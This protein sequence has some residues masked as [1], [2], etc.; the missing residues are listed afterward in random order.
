[1]PFTPFSCKRLF[2]LWAVLCT[3]YLFI[4]PAYAS[5][6]FVSAYTDETAGITGLNGASAVA[7]SQNGQ[8]VYVTGFTDNSLNVF[9]RAS[10]TGQLTIVQTLTNADVNNTGLS[11]AIDVLVS[12]DDKH[13]Y[14]ASSKDNALAVFTRNTSTGVLTLAEVLQDD[15]NGVDGLA[16]VNALAISSDGTRLYAI[17]SQENAVAVLQRH[18]DTGLL[19]FLRVRKNGVDGVGGIAGATELAISPDN[20]F[21]YVTASNDNAV[22]VFKRLPTEELEIFA[23]YVN[24]INGISGLNG[25]YGI[26][27]SQ[28]GDYLYVAGNTANSIALFQRDVN[29]GTLSYVKTYINNVEG[30]TGLSGVRHLQLSTDQLSLFA[31]GVNENSLTMFKRSASTGELTFDNVVKNNTNNINSLNGIAQLAVSSDGKHVYTAALFSKAVSLFGLQSTELVLTLTANDKAV[32]ASPFSYSLTVQNT[33]TLAA[34]NVTLTTTLPTGASF[35]QASSDTFNCQ[36]QNQTVTCSLAQLNAGAQAIATLTI[37]APSSIGNLALSAEVSA[38]EPETN[39]ANNSASKTITVADI[40]PEANLGVSIASLPTEVNINSPFTYTINVTNAGADTATNAVLTTTF[41]SDA[42]FVSSSR[43]GCT[44]NV[45]T[46]TCPLGNLANGANE[47]IQ[48]TVNTGSQASDTD[49]IFTAQISSDDL[50]TVPANNNASSTTKFKLLQLDLAITDVLATPNSVTVGS[51]IIYRVNVHNKGGTG[52]Q[53]TVLAADIAPQLSYISSSHGC[54]NTAGKLSCVLGT[55]DATAT[56]SSF[57]TITVR[58]VQASNN[59]TSSFTLSANGTETDN[60]DNTQTTAVTVTGQSADFLVTA[61]GSANPVNINTPLTYTVVVTNNGPASSTAQLQLALQGDNI[62]AQVTQGT[63]T[64]MQG[65]SLSCAI[66][67]LASNESETIELTLTPQ[68]KGVVN[69]TADVVASNNLFDPTLPNQVVLTTAVGQAV[70]DIS[71]NLEANLA[72]IK[73]GE[74]LSLSSKVNN[75]S[76]VDAD[77]VSYSLTLP[78]DVAIQSSES[79]Q[80]QACTVDTGV[81]TCPLGPLTSGAEA[82]VLVKLQAATAGEL[83]AKAEVSTT[84]FDSQQSNNSASQTVAVTQTTA[85]LSVAMTADQSSVFIQTPV[86]YTITVGNAGADPAT[87]VTINTELTGNAQVTQATL[88]PEGSGTCTITEAQVTCTANVLAKD[89]QLTAQLQL[90]PLAVGEL[91]HRVAV[92][93]VQTDAVSANNTAQV[94]ITVKELPPVFFVEAYEDGQTGITGLDRVIALSGSADGKHVY[95][96]GFG[97]QSLVSF[98]RNSNDGRLTFNSAVSQQQIATLTTPTA[99]TLSPDGAYIYVS[100]FSSA[101]INIF[102]RDTETGAASFVASVTNGDNGVSGLSGAVAL[103]ATTQALYVASAGDN[104]LVRFTRNADGTLTFAEK[105]DNLLGI[106]QLAVSPNGLWL[107][108]ANSNAD[109]VSL[110][111]KDNSTGALTLKQTLQDNP[112]ENIYLDAVS[113]LR[114]SPDS[115][116]LY[117]GA[118]GTANKLSAWGLNANNAQLSLI[119]SYDNAGL[120]GIADIAIDKNGQSV[121]AVG[122]NESSL[123]V[124]RRS[125]SQGSLEYIGRLQDNTDDINGLGSARAVFVPETGGHIYVAGFADNAISLFRSA[126]ADI[127]LTATADKATATINDDIS[128]TLTVTHNGGDQASNINLNATLSP[129]LTLTAA[130]ASQ[131]SCQ[132]QQQQVVC[133]VGNLNPQQNLTVTVHTR[134][135][136]LSELKLSATA[137]ADQFDPTAPNSAELSTAIISNAELSSQLDVTP[138][139]VRVGDSVQYSMQLQNIGTDPALNVQLQAQLPETATFESAQIGTDTSL[140]Q[141]NALTVTCTIPRLDVN[142]SAQWLLRI[143][144][145]EIG[146]FTTQFTVQQAQ[147]TLQQPHSLEVGLNI[148][149]ETINN[150]NQT[151]NDYTITAIGAVEGGIL[152]G[153]ITNNGVAI[154]VEVAENAVINGG[155]LSGTITNAGTLHNVQLLSNTHINGGKLSGTITGYPTAPALISAEILAGST[156]RYVTVGTGSKLADDVIIGKGVRFS[157]AQLLPINTPLNSAFTKTTGKGIQGIDLRYD[158]VTSQTGSLLDAINAIPALKDNNISYQQNTDTGVLS[159]LKSKQLELLLPWEIYQADTDSAMGITRFDDGRVQFITADKR[160]IT[161]YPMINAEAALNAEL[162]KLSLPALGL[163]NEA[164]LNIQLPDNILYLLRPA[165]PAEQVSSSTSLGISSTPHSAL[166]NIITWQLVF[167]HQGQR[168]RQHLYPVA[169]Q[170]QE[171]QQVLSAMPAAGNVKILSTGQVDIQL[172]NQVSQVV[173]DY[174]VTQGEASNVTQLLEIPDRNADG[175][176]DTQITYRNGMQQVLFNIPAP[177]WIDEIQGITAIQDAGYVISQTNNNYL[178]LTNSSTRMELEA[179]D[180]STSTDAATMQILDSGEVIFITPAGRKITTVPRLQAPDT[181]ATGALDRNLGALNTDNLTRLILEQSAQQQHLS[182]PALRA[183]PSNRTTGVY[184]L[185]S[186]VANND[187]L[188]VVF[189]D[190]DKK[191]WQQIVYPTAFDEAAVLAFFKLLPDVTEVTLNENG[192]IA[193]IGGQQGFT[194][195]FAYGLTLTPNSSGGIQFVLSDDFNN[196][197]VR[198]FLITFAQ[199]EQQI[200]YQNL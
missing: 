115:K 64:P 34:S 178:V 3:L 68:V 152:A 70:T 46:M 2:L 71:T 186:Q 1:M 156:L 168:Y 102:K 38:V 107:A 138:Q 92:A 60:S 85:D 126:L 49:R 155:K 147:Q 32:K 82:S 30:V 113:T 153:T 81:V 163:T 100:S 5:L 74:V 65:V 198:D 181:F 166:Q 157:S 188:L 25:A 200:I 86:T 58:G 133:S 79:T 47:A 96:V 41:P 182:R 148:I 8:H 59:I 139:R 106:N 118:A 63:C 18:T 11:G 179:V 117:I 43:T 129:A 51:E 192:N 99:V 84:T 61:T 52:A 21:I 119:A 35:S 66:P 87:Q 108:T 19:T 53:E 125:I 122:T 89:A 104:A 37:Q 12:P 149:E 29:T 170:Q 14:V 54:Q 78:A 27:L 167:E 36:T 24:G 146:V 137:F 76:G 197:G 6:T 105:Y 172:V 141:H 101:S 55:L 196:D 48:I 95:A 187:M 80:G 83:T 161:A 91:I 142:G 193:V 184:T 112:S 134:V 42:S 143:K 191:R 151:L 169:A 124:Y 33:S 16:G 69:L 116:H 56:P 110:F 164:A 158:I 88:S 189:E 4:S 26:T 72:D 128:Y 90:T 199:G 177:S 175:E 103:Q 130:V 39:T 45:N 185:S 98:T 17:G 183:T 77:N 40:L 174:S 31:L 13:V 144:P 44:Q 132:L 73:L 159:S 176:T 123:V 180:F 190:Q 93:S 97:A 20:Q 150:K 62:S 57:V 160:V 194:G 9:S 136:S 131:G 145:T 154:N 22:T 173:M 121:Y 162:D 28:A 67:L 7:L 140:C 94:V 111:S 165:N 10:S 23:S 171:L 135:N 50:D 127:N 120:N 109:T 114:F 195:Q 75:A 15:I